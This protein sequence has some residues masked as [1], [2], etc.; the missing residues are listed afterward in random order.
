[1]IEKPFIPKFYKDAQSYYTSKGM[2]NEADAFEYLIKEK[3]KNE[4]NSPNNDSK[5]RVDDQRDS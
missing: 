1:M 2:Q 5:Q 4:I 3:F